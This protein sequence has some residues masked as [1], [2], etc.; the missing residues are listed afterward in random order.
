M[1]D[2]I[3]VSVWQRVQLG[4]AALQV[5]VDGADVDVLHIKGPALDRSLTPGPRYS[6]DADLLVRPSQMTTFL[7]AL[8]RY[9][10]ELVADFE[11]GSP[12]EHAASYWHP[13]WAYVDVHRRFPGLRGDEQAFDRLWRDRM[14]VDIAGQCC[15]V[16]SVVAQRLILMLHAARKDSSHAASDLERVWTRADDQTRQAV[17]QLAAELG[18]QVGLAAATGHLDDFRGTPQWRMWMAFSDGGSRLDEW[19]AR[20]SLARGWRAKLDVTRRS[21]RVNRAH[22]AMQ[23]GHR[24][25]GVEVARAS[26]IRVA[27][28]VREVVRASL[29]AAKRLRRQQGQT[30]GERP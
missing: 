9:R 27:R 18:A 15:P 6:T 11:E 20:F 1:H 7:A 10:W 13:E 30:P 3:D 28:G 4:H 2:R 5:V 26:C 17:E 23:L 24:P 22:L 16:P 29:R 21:V 8:G 19:R 25:S 14:T 12:F